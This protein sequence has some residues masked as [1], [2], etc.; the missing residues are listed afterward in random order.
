MRRPLLFLGMIALFAF[1]SVSQKMSTKY[2]NITE[3]E[4]KMNVYTKDS[5]ANAVVLYQDAYTDYNYRETDF[6]LQSYF[7]KKIKIL[8]TEG[9]DKADIVIPYYSS[10]KSPRGDNI[11]GIEAY[12]YNLENGKVKKEKM[13]KSLIFDERINDNWK[14]VKFSIPSVKAGTVIEYK[15]T[16]NSELYQIIPDWVIQHDIPVVHSHY[17]VLIPEFFQFNVETRGYYKIDVKETSQSQSFSVRTEGIKV[18]TVPSQSR[19]IHF[20][21]EDVPAIKE[22]PFVW[23]PNDYVS[24]VIFELHGVN[25]GSY[26]PI[27]KTWKEIEELLAKDSDFGDRLKMSNPF[28]DEIRALPINQMNEEEKLDA[29][30]QLVK[31]KIKW[32]GKYAFYGNGIRDAVKNGIGNNADIFFFFLSGVG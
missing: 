28:R 15:Y 21:I 10:T 13:D 16:L 5:S 4:L 31:Q 6:R 9:C 7:K 3:D 8:T 27:T 18:V 24:R 32:N 2:G 20:T 30:C 22:D 14:Q 19:N 17:E 1:S 26:K 11:S 25:F 29:I 12:A 23:C